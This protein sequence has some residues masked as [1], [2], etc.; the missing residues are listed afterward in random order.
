MCVS[1]MASVT[2]PF[3]KL[4]N[5]TRNN[6][7]EREGETQRD[8]EKLFQQCDVKA[9]GYLGWQMRSFFN[10]LTTS[11]SV[12]LSEKVQR[13]SDCDPI[14]HPRETVCSS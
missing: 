5:S 13:G 8:G 1:L 11:L 12:A 4:N 3:I 7:R 14:T 9:K 6:K 2:T 10:Y